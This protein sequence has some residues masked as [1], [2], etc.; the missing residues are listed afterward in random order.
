MENGRAF[1]N[2]NGTEWRVVADSACEAS[3][4]MAA[5]EAIFLN[6]AANSGLPTLRLYHWNGYAVTLG[7]FQDIAR[8]IDLDACKRHNL[9][10]V[11]RITGGRGILHGGDL[12]VS[13]SAS[14]NALGL[15]HSSCS[16]LDVYRRTSELFIM[17]FQGIGIDATMGG[18]ARV[19]GQERIGDC[20]AIVSQADIV[21]RATGRKLVGAALYRRGEYLLLQAS[22]PFYAPEC[23][24]VIREMSP[25]IFGG[26][27]D[28]SKLASDISDLGGIR[29]HGIN[30]LAL[31]AA[32]VECLSMLF[33]TRI[34]YAGLNDFERAEAGELCKT[35]YGASSWNGI[36]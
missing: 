30:G 24:H 23:D 34:E 19:R 1:T 22:I 36:V 31:R 5:D 12:T 13:L 6:L 17:A 7:R 8:T 21:D 32:L 18:C 35:R 27:W 28:R 10:V 33:A 9:P 2:G 4:N 15:H 25:S 20:F 26:R 3:W 11:R 29:S 16:I 14:M